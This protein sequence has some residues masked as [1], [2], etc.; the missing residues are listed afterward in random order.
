MGLSG[1]ILMI[2][3]SSKSNTQLG[4]NDSVSSAGSVCLIAFEF[5]AYL[6]AENSKLSADSGI[7]RIP[8][9]RY[10]FCLKIWRQICFFKL[11]KESEDK[12]WHLKQTDVYFNI[13]NIYII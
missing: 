7:Q 13:H 11:L 12:N 8:L 4:G 3:K 5:T 6:S 2:C 1:F 10:E 9:F